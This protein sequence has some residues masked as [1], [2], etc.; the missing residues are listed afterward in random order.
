MIAIIGAGISGLSAAYHLNKKGIPNIVF[1]ASNRVG[2]CIKTLQETKYL[3]EE[4]PNS[5]LFTD[6]HLKLIK[7]LGLENELIEAADV[8]K[9]RYIFKNGAYRKLPSSAPALLFNSFFSWK[10][11]WSVFKELYNKRKPTTAHESVAEFFTRR[12][13]QEIVDY[14]VNP[15]MAGIYAGDPKQLLIEKAFP[16]LKEAEDE[17]GSVIKGMMAKKGSVERKLTYSFKNGLSVLPKAL[18]NHVD[19]VFETPV[20]KIE[21]EGNKL[22]V[23]TKDGRRETF[24][25]V[26]MALPAHAAAQLVKDIAPGLSD[27]LSKLKYPPMCCTHTVFRKEDISHSLDGFGGLNPE[28][29]NRFASG[30]IWSSSIFPDRTPNG[31][32]LITSFVG[33]MLNIEKAKL[34]DQ[35]ILEKAIKELKE[36]YG[37]KADPI[38]KRIS[39][40]QEA[41]P[42]YDQHVLPLDA[43]LKAAEKVN[44]FVSANWQGGV[45]VVDCIEKGEKLAQT[46]VQ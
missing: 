31:E 4:G 45:S 38:K 30:S 22:A 34:S 12:F 35:E 36:T 46:L 13:C 43:Q 1:E 20:S 24:D 40:W 3:F 18:A 10:A 41:I 5:L 37:I 33:G 42:Q 11:K 21:K 28:V 17:H 16:S 7:E 9:N 26:I 32:M 27:T 14:A 8:N 25:Q 15:F 23:V 6:T 44:L 2:G 39:R 29:E 19:I